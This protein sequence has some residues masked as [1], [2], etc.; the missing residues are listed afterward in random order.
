LNGFKTNIFN[1]LNSL[2]IL[3]LHFKV[4]KHEDLD[5]DPV[6][7]GQFISNI[8]P[9]QAKGPSSLLCN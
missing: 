3:Y 5:Q 8:E 4:N 6:K 2:I 9:L 7:V 1:K